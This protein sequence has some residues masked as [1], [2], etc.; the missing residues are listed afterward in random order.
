MPPLPITAN[1]ILLFLQRQKK[2]QNGFNAV[3][4]AFRPS[5]RFLHHH[6]LHLLPNFPI[7]LS[8]I[9]KLAGQTLWYGVPT[10]VRRFLGYIMNLTLPL[11]FA[12]P[13]TTA[14]LTQ[15][16][17]IIPFLNILF[18]YGLETAYFRFSREAD[19]KKLYNTLSVSLI[20]ST[21][22]FTGILLIFKDSIA[23]WANLDEHPEYITWMAAIIFFDSISTLAFARLRQE[24]RPRRYAFATVAGVL[25][26]I[27]VVVLFLAIIPKYVQK[28]P[29]TFPGYILQ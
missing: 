6:H 4:D 8:G 11:I 29:H 10:I 3:Q 1:F 27:L 5:F 28:N 17:A 20:G 23:Q 16:Y 13:S 15:M 12:Q 7:I 18:T 25:L 9:K 19:Q 26:N 22:F 21:I 24:N 2:S 14:D